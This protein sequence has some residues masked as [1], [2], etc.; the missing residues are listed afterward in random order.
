MIVFLVLI[1]AFPPLTTDVYLPALPQLKEVL[2]TTQSMVN[3]TLS[4]YFVFFATGMLFWGPLSE[5]Y[6]RKRILLIGV[7]FYIGASLGCAAAQD[8]LQ[9]VACRVVQAFAGSAPSVVAAAIVKDLYTGRDREKALAL[10]FSMVVIAPIVAPVVGAVLLSYT[11]WR[12]LFVLLAVVGV[13]AF[14]VAQFLD[15]TISERYTGSLAASWGRLATVMLNP[16]FAILMLLFSMIPMTFMSFLAASSFIYVD[17]FSMSERQYSFFLAFNSC[18]CMLAPPLYVRLSKY[19]QPKHIITLGFFLLAGAGLLIIA[20]G[21]SSPYLF[22]VLVGIA[23][24]AV[25]TL[26]VPATNLMLEQQKDDTGS[27]SALISFSGMIMASVGMYLV[28]LSP[29]NLIQA[30]GTI[31][32]TIGILCVIFWL[33][34]RNK[35][36]AR[37]DF[38][39]S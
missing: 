5:K 2:Q 30:L 15:E 11:S 6:G 22:A 17:V 37:Y 16:G 19:L 10:V 3:L 12:A 35:S 29:E 1:S 31:Q 21:A 27:A 33:I 39:R 34:I 25:I 28:T 36:F 7:A 23:T 13:V 18:F 26:K 14:V 8:I 20:I 24:L 32:V 9:L 38:H 4:L